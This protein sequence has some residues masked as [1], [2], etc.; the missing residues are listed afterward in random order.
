MALISINGVDLPTP[1]EFQVSIQDIRSE[2]AQ[3]NAAGYLIADVVRAGV[4]KIELGWKFLTAEQMSLVLTAVAPGF[5]SVTYPDPQTGANRTGTFYSS[6]R[7]AP[8]M[9]FKNGVPRYANVK[10]NLV[11]R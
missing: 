4:R 2:D 9:D 10:F 7:P 8:M 5:F 11:E 1:S 6:D 3:R